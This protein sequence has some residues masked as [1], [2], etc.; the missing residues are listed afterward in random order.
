MRNFTERSA[1]LA[2]CS[3]DVVNA[4]NK[5]DPVLRREQWGTQS[6]EVLGSDQQGLSRVDVTEAEG[7]SCIPKERRSARR[8]A[9]HPSAEYAYAFRCRVLEQDLQGRD[10][11]FVY[12]VAL[13]QSVL[14]QVRQRRQ[15]N[16][17][18]AVELLRYRHR[19]VR[20]RVARST[21]VFVLARLTVYQHGLLS[22]LTRSGQ[23]SSSGGAARS[24]YGHA[25]K[26]YDHPSHAESLQ[27]VVGRGL[28]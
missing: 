21:F 15:S 7:R 22:C 28:G 24:E 14:R 1:T 11:I 17:S 16:L 18:L 10:P 12:E 26:F 5:Q 6:D 3:D 4:R 2:R 19:E 13:L 9:S 27:G 8:I 25:A 20:A 23:Q